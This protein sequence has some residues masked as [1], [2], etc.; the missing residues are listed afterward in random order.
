M[1]NGLGEG[2]GLGSGDVEVESVV[3]RESVGFGLGEGRE[4]GDDVE[5]GRER[6]E[7]GGEERVSV[8][9][10]IADEVNCERDW[11]GGEGEG[12]RGE[13]GERFFD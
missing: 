10:K 13:M 12:E 5:G 9:G 4:R 6:R 11:D 7:K 3:E 2:L 1:G 8:W